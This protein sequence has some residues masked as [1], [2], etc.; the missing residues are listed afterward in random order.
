MTKMWKTFLI[1]PF[2]IWVSLVS[3]YGQG[4]KSGTGKSFLW[5]IEGTAGKSYL[6]GSVHLLK[7]EHYPLKKTV[8]DA[9]EQSDVLAVEADVSGD[10]LMSQGMV[11]L[12]KGMYTGEETLEGNISPKTYQLAVKKLK[13]L[14]MDIGGFKKFKPWLLAMTIAQMEL[15]KLGFSPEYGIEIYFLERASGKKE[16]AELEGIEFQVK[17][18]DGLSKAESEGFLLANIMEADMMGKEL[19]NMI[20]AW[21]TGDAKKMERLLTE[22]IQK[23]PDLDDLYKKLLDDR[24]EGMVEKI[25]NYLKS[26]KTYFIVAGAAHM[27]GKK[28]VV[29][30]LE[31]KGIKTKHL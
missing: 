29:Q 12:Q 5:E 25:I 7:K 17:L 4:E 14:G 18:F 11:L 20:D 9:F 26:G 21:A 1:I 28:G 10:K 30:L 15:V 2:I 3:V 16:I 31:D 23:T 8:E 27:V 6:L 22:N 13:E 24:N 19:D